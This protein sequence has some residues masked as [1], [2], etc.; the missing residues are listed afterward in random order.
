MNY[1][2]RMLATGALSV[3]TLMG[4]TN[5][6]GTANQPGT[7]AVIGGL[8]GAAAGQIIGGNTGCER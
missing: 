4:C 7:G 8:T 3:A 2:A 6:D 5:M 1:H